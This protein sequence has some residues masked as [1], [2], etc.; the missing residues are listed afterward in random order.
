MI[1]L[2][3]TTQHTH[4]HTQTQRKLWDSQ[5]SIDV[6]QEEATKKLP[7][8]KAPTFILAHAHNPLKTMIS[9][10]TT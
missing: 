3:A 5:T 2:A 4:T 9:Y 10:Q 7:G 6:E 8:Y 1:S